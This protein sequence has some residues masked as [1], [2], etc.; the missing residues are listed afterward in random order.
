MV[1]MEHREERMTVIDEI[2]ESQDKFKLAYLLDPRH[3]CS[4]C[5]GLGNVIREYWDLSH[6]SKI[7][8]ECCPDCL[9]QGN[10]WKVK[11]K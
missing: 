9:G 2:K 3:R 11:W 7:I 5:G 4:T 6:E 8:Y 1:Q 10:I